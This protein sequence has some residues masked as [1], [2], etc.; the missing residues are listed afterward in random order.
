M[1]AAVEAINLAKVFNGL[2]AVDDISFQ[3]EKGELFGLLG[4]NGAG[5]TTTIRMLCTLL[6]PTSGTARVAG[7]DVVKEPEKVRSKIGVV[8]EGVMLYRDLTAYENLELLGRLYRVPSN[9]LRDRINKLLDFLDL[10]ERAHDLVGNFSTGLMKRTQVAAA[11][12]HEPDVLFLDEVTS[13]LDPQSAT[14]LRE[15][16]R[17]LCRE[18]ITTIWTT[19]YMFEPERLCDR[20]AII[21]RG[22]LLII[23]TPDGVRKAAKDFDV[24]EV[25]MDGFDERALPKIREMPG[26]LGL[27]FSD[28][29][30]RL[31][32]KDHEVVFPE[33]LE[34]IRLS[35]GV[36]R[37]VNVAV[38][39]LEEAFIRLTRGDSSERNAQ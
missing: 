26:V 32:V 15:L 19:H 14:S 38:P 39:S 8:S 20:V 4:P 34:A 13:G 36:V 27:F 33:I 28:N 30:L 5:K 11:L 1:K 29:K 16:T 3:V 35:G 2:T 17:N 9:E 37:S 6:E 31:M 23:D 24:L 10:K 25:M 12:I 7:F 18:G 21:N 22:K